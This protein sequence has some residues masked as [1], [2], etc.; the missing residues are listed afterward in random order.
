MTTMG[1]KLDGHA[2][3]NKKPFDW[4]KVVSLRKSQKIS[5]RIRFL[6]QDLLDLKE[7]RKQNQSTKVCSVLSYAV[8]SSLFGFV[9]WVTRRKQETAKN[10]ADLHKEIAK[11]E[12]A[13]AKSSKMNRRSNSSNN[14]RRSQSMA[15]TP[16]VDD[17]G[18]V[19]ISRVTMKNVSSK[20]DMMNINEINA[21]SQPSSVPD[22]VIMRRSQSQP[23]SMS[24]FVPD[25]S[26]I[27]RKE[28]EV[29]SPNKCSDKAKNLLK[30]YFVGG[31]TSDA[32]LTIHEIVQAGSDGCVERGSKV[33]EGGVFLVMEMK[34]GEVEKCATVLCRAFK[35]N[36]LPAE[37][38]SKG[39]VDP[40][41]FLSD[42]EIDAPLAGSHLAF[43]IAEFI[44]AGA[45]E[46]GTFLKDAPEYF[47]TD[48]KPAVFCSKVLKAK[49]RDLSNSDFELIASLMTN[50]DKSKFADAKAIYASV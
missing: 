23:A 37:S 19:Q 38:M 5:N 44:K 33:V 31:D 45:I 10:I 43:I 34:Q 11:E 47:K 1:E 25:S 27:E 40:L 46:L 6:L 21:E 2:K 50:D 4:N 39:L 16:A 28:I 35:E 17:D 15:S 49:N 30:E 18:F 41:E 7:N 14:L 32:I 29:L 8:F 24:T 20:L 9:D 22:K 26:P 42:I 36:K 12:K 3:Q 13:A 48:G